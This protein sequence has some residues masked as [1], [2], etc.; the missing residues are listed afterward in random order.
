M[1]DKLMNK[2]E[3]S[4]I[5]K[6]LT[7]ENC[8]ITRI[9][10]CYVDSEKNKKTEIVEA[11]LSL[12]EEE[13]FKYFDLFRKTL[14]G[15]AGKNLLTMDFPLDAEMPGG[16]QHFLLKLRSSHLED[17]E[18]LEEFYNKIIDHYDYGE[19]YLILL[20]HALYDIPGKAS[21]NLDMFDASDEVF[22]YILCAVCP[23]KLSKAGLSYDAKENHF[24]SRIRDWMVEMPDRGFLFPAFH[25]R[26]TDI[27]SFLYYS[28]NSEDLHEHFVETV[29]GSPMPMT[30][31][32]QK[33]TF[34]FVVEETLAETCDYQLVRN[35][36]ER[37]NEMVNDEQDSP[38]PLMLSKQ[39]VRSLLESS[40]ADHEK[41]EAFD[42]NF[43]E[44]VGAKASLLASNV[45]NTKKFEIKTPSVTIQVDPD[46]ADLVETRIID[47]RRCL[48]IGIDDQVAVNGISIAPTEMKD[49]KFS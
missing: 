38:E 37:L 31:K 39:E 42:H 35:I 1:P 34:N 8:A 26:G 44:A 13:R 49:S 47:G 19:N 46:C 17:G 29:F 16:G 9:C 3:I 22:D 43:D 7:P 18:L 36:H 28:K 30:A 11:F 6:Q 25:D 10:G 27:H 14:S 41:M 45:M 4:E 32:D 21:D 40:G 15:T 5:K 33:E 23:V 2:K 24:C 12:P 20:I 48:V